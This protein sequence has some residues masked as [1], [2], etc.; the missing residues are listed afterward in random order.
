MPPEEYH[1]EA[2][3]P[4]KVVAMIV[5]YNVLIIALIIYACI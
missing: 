4:M 3:G 5:I 1:H 2:Q